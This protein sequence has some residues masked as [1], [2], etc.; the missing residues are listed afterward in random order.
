MQVIHKRDRILQISVM[1]DVKILTRYND[2]RFNYRFFAC[3]HAA[4]A[5][6]IY[7]CYEYKRDWFE[8][9]NRKYG[10]ILDT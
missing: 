8:A 6:Y 4:F 10:I 3:T 2:L 9:V 7:L 5:V 1:E